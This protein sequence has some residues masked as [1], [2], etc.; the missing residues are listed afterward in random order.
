MVRRSKP[1]ALAQPDLAAFL[2]AAEAL[3]NSIV[4]PRI[5][6]QCDHYRSMQD[7]H[8]VLLK[9]VKDVTGK[10]AAF[11]RWFGAGSK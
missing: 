6:P 3:H 4:G 1:K 8:E 10:D 7:L 2:A 9:T 11:I 5:S